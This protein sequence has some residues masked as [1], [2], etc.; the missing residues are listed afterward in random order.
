MRNLKISARMFIIAIALL[1]PFAVT[2]YGLLGKLNESIDFSE[3]QIKGVVY[4]KPL[5]VLLNEIAD[6]QVSELRKQ[7][8]DTSAEKDLQEGAQIIEKTFAEL[9]EIDIKIGADLDFTDE[10]MKKHS[11]SGIKLSDHVKKWEE[12][13]SAKL[14][15]AEAY[16]ALL[17]AL[18]L[19]IKQLGDSSGMI[20]DPDLD[21]Y[22]LVDAALASFPSLL[23][24]LSDIKVT[25]YKN[26]STNDNVY[27]VS[28]RPQLAK[29]L[30]TISD[31]LLSKTNDDLGTTFREDANF[32]GVSPT[33][34]PTLEPALSKYN[35]ETKDISEA[36][37][38][39]LRGE[40]VEGS[41]FIE[42]ADGLHD[43]ASDLGQL[44]LNELKKLLEIRI[45]NLKENRMKTVGLCAISLVFAFA[46]FFFVSTGITG[47]ITRLT[48]AMK[49]LA[50]GDLAV[51]VP[52]T[53]NKDE[54]GNMAKA[55]LV[56]KNN[57]MENEQLKASQEEQN[58]RTEVEKRELMQKM[59]N[60]FESSIKSIVSGVAAAATELSQ[61]ARDM[62]STVS[63]SSHLAS[64]AT[65]AAHSTNA[66]IQSVASATEELS[67]SV[68]EISGQLQKT[69]M[70]VHQS[71]EKAENADKLAA[72]LGAA[73]RRVEEVM[74]MI[75][76][77]AGQINLLALN[78]TIESARAGEAG[79]GFAVVA[80]EV[81]NLAGQTDKSINE[82]KKVIEEMRSASD[83]IAVALSEIKASV[84][85]ISTA[86][87][88][89]ASAVEE[90]S[91][92]TS[93][94]SRSMQTA[95]HGTQTVTDNLG[96][97]SANAGAAS[98]QMLAASLELSQ[99][100]EMLNIQVDSFIA[101]IR[102][103]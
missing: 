37:E 26:L 61:T 75:S 87:T 7:N 103:S 93:E 86:T 49:Y 64:G 20:L 76:D 34:K 59:A 77:I 60:D 58:K 51:E 80:S 6:Y 101:K 42:I 33:L 16:S 53:E 102:N 90:Q 28:E 10:G 71:T 32:N 85:N 78:A 29:T 45:D 57:M 95:A 82:T 66:N 52:S 68:R 41:K 56:F 13:K 74:G 81:K 65:T 73:S 54:I 15:S 4:E 84:S 23:G 27:P 19:S 100:A 70:L 89:V 21:S 12:I 35:Y 8:G 1:I 83:A 14:Y 96:Q 40:R 99:Q 38:N 48:D 3:L 79:K 50:D 22:Y 92:T 46:M 63:T 97:V 67:A 47:P 39:L 2:G 11:N 5:L 31:V 44:T 17:S 43:E 24:T 98:E 36:I 62:S 94:I 69:N 91:A 9:A 25:V 18:S 72:D 55:V 30:Q 88:T